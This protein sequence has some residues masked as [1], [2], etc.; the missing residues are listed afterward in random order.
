MKRIPRGSLLAITL[1]A[2]LSACA[3][4]GTRVTTDSDTYKAMASSQQWWCSQFGCGCTMDGQQ[5][6]CALVSTCVN[7]GSCKQASP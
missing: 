2:M 5:A 6:T 3:S 4:S 1:C 7:A